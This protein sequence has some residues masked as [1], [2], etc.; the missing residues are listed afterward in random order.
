MHAGQAS[1][2]CPAFL[3]LSHEQI[4]RELRSQYLLG[5][6]PSNFRLDGSFRRIH[7]KVRGH[8]YMVRTRTG[9]YD[10]SDERADTKN[11]AQ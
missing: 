7:V 5:Y 6:S 3:N 1:S 2:T 8:N 4:A 10:R 9:Y 11:L